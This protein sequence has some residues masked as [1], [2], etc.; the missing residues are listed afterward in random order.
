MLSILE[1]GE[2][3][4]KNK[5]L[6]NRKKMPKN[7]FLK[8]KSPI[9]KSSSTARI[10]TNPIIANCNPYYGQLWVQ[11]FPNRTYVSGSK[12]QIKPFKTKS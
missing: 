12:P 7:K 8:K 6:Q 1:N 4:T 5:Y 2:K 11:F 3:M 10:S 9:R